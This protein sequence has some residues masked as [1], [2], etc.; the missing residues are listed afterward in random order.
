MRNKTV[1]ANGPPLDKVSAL[2]SALRSAPPRKSMRSRSPLKAAVAQ[3]LPDLLAFRA[4]GYTSAEL[5]EIMRENGFTIAAAT[6]AKYINEARARTT[7]RRKNKTVVATEAKAT[8]VNSGSGA[9]DATTKIAAPPSLLSTKPLA[10]N[11]KA[12]KDVLGHRFDY[13]V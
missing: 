2:R 3:L 7:N 4:K 1:E 12:A 10:Q 5:A 13:D 9:A 6:L 8:A 11:R